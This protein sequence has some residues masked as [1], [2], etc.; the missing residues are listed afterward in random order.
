M[1]WVINA[2]PWPLF[3]S[4]KDPVPIV[5]EAGLGPRDGLDRWGKS[6]PRRDSILVGDVW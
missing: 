2:T 6:R 3:T 1:G 4:G 5:Q